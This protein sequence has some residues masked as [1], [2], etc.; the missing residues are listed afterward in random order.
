DARKFSCRGRQ[1]HQ[2]ICQ[3]K[4]ILMTGS[5]RPRLVAVAALV[6]LMSACA[7]HS[8][9]VDHAPATALE[10]RLDEVLHRVQDAPQHYTARVVDLAT[11]KEVYSVDAD[12]PY[13][14]AS[15]GKLSV[16]AATLDCLGPDYTFKTYLALDGNDLWIIGT[17]DPG[18]GDAMIARKYGG[19][20]MT[21]LEHWADELRA[22][23]VAHI[24]GN[25]YYY[26]RAFDDQWTCPSWS[27]SY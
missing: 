21:V 23:G 13:M 8:T 17:G 14:P 16:G 10:R 11:G 25:L 3:W 24:S 1:A 18:I 27:R 4:D 20:T 19:T 7:S 22:K 15:N 9:A 5:F 6:S 26:D 12:T 2:V